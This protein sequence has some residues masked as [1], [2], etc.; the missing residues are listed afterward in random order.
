MTNKQTLVIATGNAGKVKEF[1]HILGEDHFIYKTL[2]DVGFTDP[3][4]EDAVSFQGNAEIKVRAVAQWVFSRGLGDAVLADD[5]G[6]EVDALGGAPGV[7][8][9]RYAGE[10]AS[11]EANN[12]KLLADL[13]G[14]KDRGARFVCCL[15]FVSP[16]ESPRFFFGECRGT[17]LEAPVGSQGFGYDPVF[18]PTKG[19]G[20][21]FAQMEQAEKKALSHRGEAIKELYAYMKTVQL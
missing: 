8:T 20:R 21:S 3:I 5:S 1:L 18:K 6:L 16:G 17:I 2:A 7:Y 10:G 11:D 4:A 14:R 15:G 13:E 19:D 9:A 12:R